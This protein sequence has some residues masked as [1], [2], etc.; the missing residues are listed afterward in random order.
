M[1]WITLDGGDALYVSNSDNE[2]IKVLAHPV[3]ILDLNANPTFE[4]TSVDNDITII[5]TNMPIC[6]VTPLVTNGPVTIICNR[7]MSGSILAIP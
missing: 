1:N 2:I 3:G 5:P 6:T 4:S 7:I